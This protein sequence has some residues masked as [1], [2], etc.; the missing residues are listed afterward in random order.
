M[1]SPN[2][3]TKKRWQV[4]EKIIEPQIRKRKHS[5]RS[6]LNDIST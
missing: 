1:N 5:L 2:Y 6:V 4:I 3:L